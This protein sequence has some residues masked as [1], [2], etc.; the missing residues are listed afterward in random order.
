MTDRPRGLLSHLVLALGHS[1][2]QHG[3]TLRRDVRGRW[4]A[5]ARGAVDK[6]ERANGVH[7][8]ERRMCVLCVEVEGRRVAEVSG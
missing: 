1:R 2:G 6:R 5:R 7:L 4:R 8:E 3:Q